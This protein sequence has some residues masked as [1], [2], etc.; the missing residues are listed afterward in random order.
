MGPIEDKAN[1]WVTLLRGSVQA[2]GVSG[3]ILLGVLFVVW[4]GVNVVEP[5]LERV[6]NAAIENIAGQAESNRRTT[7]VLEE[8][9]QT[10]RQQVQL[11]EGLHDKV[12]GAIG[13]LER[14]ETKVDS[15]RES[16]HR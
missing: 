1:F 11:I 9:A 16:N 2:I 7:V 3:V 8:Q 6:T 14:I 12:D 15:S 13:R 10:Q 5:K 4:R